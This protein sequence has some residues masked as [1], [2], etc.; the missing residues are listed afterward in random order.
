M[1]TAYVLSY[2]GAIEIDGERL[3]IYRWVKVGW[4]QIKSGMSSRGII[5]DDKTG[6]V[7]RYKIESKGETLLKILSDGRLRELT[8]L[9]KQSDNV[10]F[11]IP[12]I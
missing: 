1:M 11:Q 10:K 9:E 7:V 6:E 4:G 12:R 3:F 5:P 8:S 2:D